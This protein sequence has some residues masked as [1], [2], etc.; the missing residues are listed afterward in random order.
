MSEG[1][2]DGV[3]ITQRVLKSINIEQA[4]DLNKTNLNDLGGLEGL[5]EKLGVSLQRGL[6][7]EKVI[8][9]RNCFESNE[10]ADS[11]MLFKI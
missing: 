6:T 3:Y 11:P 5:A 9:L 2:H 4:R 10:F 8:E 1:T 7:I